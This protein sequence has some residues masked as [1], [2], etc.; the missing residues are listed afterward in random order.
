MSPNP[1]VSVVRDSKQDDPLFVDALAR[2]LAVLRCFTK[3]APELGTAEIAKMIDLPQPTV[4]RL[5]HTL[6]QLGYLTQAK[7]GKK[8]RLGV[9]VLGLGYSVLA[10]LE[11]TALSQPYMRELAERFQESISLAALDRLEIIF[12]QRCEVPSFMYAGGQ[13]GSRSPITRAPAGWALLAGMT[14]EDRENV[15]AQIRAT[16]PVGWAN[17]AGHIEAAIQQYAELGFVTNFG[18][19]QSEFHAVSV[20]IRSPDNK[21][22][23]ALTCVGLR[24]RL[25]NWKAHE[26]GAVLT[27]VAD[28]LSMALRRAG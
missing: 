26:I 9:P 18:K 25:P 23:Y 1:L 11:I 13:A 22:I 6:R 15:T 3:Q 20:P 2:G 21:P 24:S 28:T 14:V 5:C 16:D 10:N 7:S 4:W 12:V 17:M 8:L 27:R 19:V